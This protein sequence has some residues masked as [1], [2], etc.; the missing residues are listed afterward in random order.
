MFLLHRVAWLQ[1]GIS[2][3]LRLS[4]GSWVRTLAGGSK[5]LWKEL[6]GVTSTSKG[7]KFRISCYQVWFQRVTP[8]KGMD[9]ASTA[10]GDVSICIRPALAVHVAACKCWEISPHGCLNLRHPHGQWIN[11]QKN[12]WSLNLVVNSKI[13]G[14]WMFIPTNKKCW[15]IPI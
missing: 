3:S 7:D 15:S 9:F 8:F 5:P 6:H 10:A 2:L 14:K 12:W 13:A 1:R 11:S 4:L